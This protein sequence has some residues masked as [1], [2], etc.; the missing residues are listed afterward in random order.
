MNGI[1]EMQSNNDVFI[2][3]NLQTFPINRHKLLRNINRAE[4]NYNRIT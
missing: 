4:K 1:A 3:F 2:N